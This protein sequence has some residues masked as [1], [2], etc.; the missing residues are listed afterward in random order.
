[1]IEGEPHSIKHESIQTHLQ[2]Q[3]D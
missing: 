1:M 3:P 2:T